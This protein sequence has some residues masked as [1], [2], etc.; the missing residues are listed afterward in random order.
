MVVL[1][2]IHLVIEL[3]QFKIIVINYL[4]ISLKESDRGMRF[5]KYDGQIL[6][7]LSK[8]L[9]LPLSDNDFHKTYI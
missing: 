9:I 4:S 2:I 3:L 6:Y 5:S 8:R 1:N 7:K